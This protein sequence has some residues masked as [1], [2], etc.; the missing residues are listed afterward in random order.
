[1]LKNVRQFVWIRQIIVLQREI[2]PNLA[3]ELSQSTPTVLL[4][5]MLPK[6]GFMLRH[7]MPAVAATTREIVDLLN[8]RK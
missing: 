3:F 5:L 2:H 7:A 4:S 1:M 8:S 6:R